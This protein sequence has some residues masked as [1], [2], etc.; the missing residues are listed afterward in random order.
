MAKNHTTN[1]LKCYLCR[2]TQAAY[3]T[4]YRG[5]QYA[6]IIR[7]PLKHHEV[8]ILSKK[9]NDAD[10]TAVH[11]RKTIFFIAFGISCETFYWRTDKTWE[12]LDIHNRVRLDNDKSAI[13][14]THPIASKKPP[15]TQNQKKMQKP[16]REDYQIGKMGK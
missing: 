4:T 1:P 3:Q 11:W 16:Q 12:L 7:E 14:L 15:S 13:D 2:K 10:S 5:H 8:Y 6:W 9:I